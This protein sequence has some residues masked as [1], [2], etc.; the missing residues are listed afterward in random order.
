MLAPRAA[1]R[2]LREQ[3]NPQRERTYRTMTCS[4]VKVRRR[5]A[6]AL[7]GLLLAFGG[8]CS[9]PSED[10]FREIRQLYDRRQYAEALE[11]LRPLEVTHA[12]NPE[13]DLL[14]ARVLAER[15]QLNLAIEPLRRAA[16]SAEHA[17][18]ANV[19]LATILM[20]L[21]EF[22]EAVDVADRA[23]ELDPNE[24]AAWHVRARA[25]LA[26][27]RGREALTDVERA[28]DLAPGR[29]DYQLTRVLVLLLLR[30]FDEAAVV[31]GSAKQRLAEAPDSSRQIAASLCVAEARLVRGTSDSEDVGRQIARCSERF[32]ANPFVVEA[33]L[34]LYDSLDR[35]DDAA[36]VLRAAIEA[37]PENSRYYTMLANRLREHGEEGEAERFLR[38]EIERAP[39]VAVWS[40]LARHL[41]SAGDYA[42]AASAYREA[43][44]ISEGSAA[45]TQVSLRFAYADVLVQLGALD[46][47]R[48]LI[49]S[50]GGSAHADLLRGRILLLEGDAAGALAALERG[51]RA[52]PKDAVARYLVGQ[53]AERVGDFERAAREYQVSR[54]V[55]AGETDAGIAL[56][57]LYEAQGKYLS[58]LD[59]VG[60]YLRIHPDDPEAYALGMRAAHHLGRE[61]RERGLGRKLSELPGQEARAVVERAKW[62]A[63]ADGPAAAIASVETSGL[64]LSDPVHAEALRV[65]LEQLAAQGYHE[66]ALTR[67]DA[68]LKAHPEQADLHRLRGEVL[69]RAGRLDAA[70]GAFERA[71]ALDAGDANALAGL[72]RLAAARRDDERALSLYA[73][74]LEAAPEDASIAFAHAALLLERERFDAAEQNLDLLLYRYPRHAPAAHERAKRL[75]EQGGDSDR[76]LDL[77]QRAVMF[78]SES[79]ALETL[80]LVRL[81]RGEAE[82]AVEVLTRAAQA[83]PHSARTHYRLGLARIAAG[84][85][86]GAR[87]ALRAALDL[88]AFPEAA[89]AR[90]QLAQLRGAGESTP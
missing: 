80:G 58:A 63:A 53:A 19:L 36:Q 23:L 49:D 10:P 65:V 41:Q 9:E 55:G 83:Q 60:G 20:R 8:G 82:A 15:R 34:D 57:S 25:N 66:R 14:Y 86:A 32:P 44:A 39:S 31:L 30:R 51:I 88:G 89:D 18:D 42:G 24:S 47:A 17:V 90:A 68:A 45:D 37:W 29:Q 56:A 74:A 16:A 33:A 28:L 78:G 87:Q 67:I 54:R 79:E 35:P 69:E 85:A 59:V 84:D 48:G 43:L 81:E 11:R 50:F 22:A 64:D 61:R 62:V 1:H 21:S 7:V 3:V 6:A 75:L 2:A 71:V 5:C 72:A 70:D 26:R 13:F 40:A 27:R 12:G 76:A 52:R 4:L 73:R 38:Q 77:A 46:E